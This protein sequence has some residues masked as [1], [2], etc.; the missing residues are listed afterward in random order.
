MSALK[1]CICST[2]LLWIVQSA[3]QPSPR[4]YSIR[5]KELNRLI[6][7]A[8]SLLRTA[9]EPLELIIK[10]RNLH[11]LVNIKNDTDH[12]L[13]NIMLKLSVI[14]LRTLQLHCKI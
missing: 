12:P 8:G 11:K 1:C 10:R 3:F 14:T 5:A 7:K 4:G 13:H 2:S 6:K 9:L